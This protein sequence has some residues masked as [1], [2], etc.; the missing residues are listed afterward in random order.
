MSGKKT[1]LFVSLSLLSVTAGGVLGLLDVFG[2]IDGR[3]EL[4]FIFLGLSIFV[5]YLILVNIFILNFARRSRIG[6][7][8]VAATF[9]F[10]ITFYLVNL[11]AI[12]AIFSTLAYLLFLIYALSATSKRSANQIKFVPSEIFL[13]VL[14]NSFLYLLIIFAAIAFTQS[15]QRVSNNNLIN[16]ELVRI[17][18]RLPIYSLNQQVNNQISSQL[19]RVPEEVLQEQSREDLTRLIIDSIVSSSAQ[20]TG[21]IYGF[22][23]EE[24]PVDS[25]AV[26][27]DGSIDITPMIDQML[28]Q[29]AARLNIFIQDYAVAAPFIVALITALILQPIMFLINMFEAF[30]TLVIFKVLIASK[31]I[32]LQKVAAQIDKLSL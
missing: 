8:F 20:G 19:N 29:I 1:F 16:P 25:I 18:A 6:A 23:P 11:S 28:P 14:R 3:H 30:L 5:I 9:F 27:N 13:P 12:L 17:V 10:G 7:I 32:K 4:S 26:S 21:D 22:K 31:F 24:I 2:F 15:Q